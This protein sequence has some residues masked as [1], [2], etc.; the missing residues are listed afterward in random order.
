MYIGSYNATESGRSSLVVLLYGQQI[1]MGTD[2]LGTDVTVGDASTGACTATGESIGVGKVPVVARV[3]SGRTVHA[4]DV[5]GNALTSGG[6]VFDLLAR[7]V[8]KTGDGDAD[9]PTQWTVDDA[10]PV[11][12]SPPELQDRGDGTYLS[13][14][15][16]DAAGTYGVRDARRF[17]DQGVAVPVHRGAGDDQRGALHARMRRRRGV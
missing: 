13:E 14:F 2:Y 8:N 16:H 4:R 6:S 15:V 12:I 17:R 3:A 7:P 11:Y 9:D 5:F 10:S 1:K